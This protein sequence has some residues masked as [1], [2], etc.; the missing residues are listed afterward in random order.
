MWEVNGPLQMNS[1][2]PTTVPRQKI[3]KSR[4]HFAFD[5]FSEHS[6]GASSC[7]LSAWSIRAP[8]SPA[9]R[10]SKPMQPGVEEELESDED[11]VEALGSCCHF[12]IATDYHGDW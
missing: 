3:A 10:F 2:T 7:V 8:V 1:A 9:L 12:P 4:C 5:S 11:G 6:C